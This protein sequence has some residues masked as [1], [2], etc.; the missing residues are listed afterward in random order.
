MV[1][2]SKPTPS[3][4]AMPAGARAQIF[5]ADAGDNPF[6]LMA[7]HAGFSASVRRFIG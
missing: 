7:N 5:G 3:P 1:D 6:T 2:E 4:R